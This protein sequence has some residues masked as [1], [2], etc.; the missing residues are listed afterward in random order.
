MSEPDY[1]AEIR[2]QRAFMMQHVPHS[3]AIG[4]TFVDVEPNAAILMVPYAEKLVGNPDTGVIHGGVITSLLDNASGIAVHCHMGERKGMATL[5]LR[6]DYMR[7]AT[8]GEDVYGRAECY[9]VTNNVAFVRG[10]AYHL[11]NGQHRLDD[12]IAT[13]VASF[14]ITGGPIADWKDMAAQAAGGQLPADQAESGER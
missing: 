12:P 10:T 6:I 7:P 1:L 14:M 3:A 9:K 8:P 13:C 11:N 4:M 2:E 5:D